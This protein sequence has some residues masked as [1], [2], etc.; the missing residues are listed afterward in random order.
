MKTPKN[1]GLVGKVLLGVGSLV[2]STEAQTGRLDIDN[3]IDLPYTNQTHKTVHYH[4]ASEGYDSYDQIYGPM[5]NPSGISSKIVSII[6]GHEFQSDVRPEESTTPVNLELSLISQ[7]GQ[8]I[9]INSSN[10]LR[11]VINPLNNGWNFGTKPITLELDNGQR[12]NV[13]TLTNN[14]TTTGIITLPDLNGTYN[15]EEVYATPTLHF[16][17]LADLDNDG[18]VNLF[19]YSILASNWLGSELGDISGINGLPDGKVD[20]YDLAEMQN[21]WLD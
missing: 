5:F 12:Y 6:P 21:Q 15:S 9:T 8:P 17:N 18:I 2:G 20:F 16:R 14:G 1:L 11:C 13:R 4:G 19:D 7:N 3:H 10:E